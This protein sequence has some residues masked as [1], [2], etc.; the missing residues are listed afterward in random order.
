[1]DTCVSIFT[2]SFPGNLD[3]SCDLG[4]IAFVYKYYLSLMGYWREVLPNRILD[5][6]Y[7]GIIADREKYLVNSLPTLAWSGMI[8]VLISHATATE[9]VE[10]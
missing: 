10:S 8:G 4:D 1:M 3:F 2:N 5:V 6:S 9:F 7:E